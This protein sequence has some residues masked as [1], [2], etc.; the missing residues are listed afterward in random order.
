MLLAF[1]PQTKTNFQNVL[2]YVLSDDITKAKEI[3]SKANKNQSY[4]IVFPTTRQTGTTHWL[5]PP[6]KLTS[7]FEYLLYAQEIIYE[8]EPNDFH[9][10]HFIL[11]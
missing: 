2:F 6:G 10:R 7:Y 9:L 5:D 8:N 11:S 3:L 4:N 1:H